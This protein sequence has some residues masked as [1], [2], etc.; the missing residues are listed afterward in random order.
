MAVNFVE[1]G[2][3]CS[4]TLPAAPFPAAGAVGLPAV[5]RPLESGQSYAATG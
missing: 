4:K 5:A 1:R 3:D 2:R